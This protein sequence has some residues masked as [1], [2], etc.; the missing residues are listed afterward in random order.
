MH[1]TKTLIQSREFHINILSI[2]A[3]NSTLKFWFIKELLSGA[4]FELAIC[5]P[6]FMI[7]PLIYFFYENIGQSRELKK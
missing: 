6:S 1:F 2:K 5:I 3:S 4:H 7:Q